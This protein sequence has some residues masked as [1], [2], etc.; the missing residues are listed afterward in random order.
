VNASAF[1]SILQP[2]ALICFTEMIEL[3]A[4][5]ARV[6]LAKAVNGV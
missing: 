6:K 4:D 1:D 5:I 2:L 3:E